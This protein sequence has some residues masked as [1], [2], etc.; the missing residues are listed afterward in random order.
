MA[1]NHMQSNGKPVNGS[2]MDRKKLDDFSHPSVQ[3][4]SRGK[5]SA[6]LQS[7]AGCRDNQSSLPSV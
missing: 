1:Q 2:R 6:I 4:S 5:D 3:L 7:E